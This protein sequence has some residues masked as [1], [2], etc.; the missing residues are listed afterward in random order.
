MWLGTTRP[1][2]M[3][4]RRLDQS[5]NNNG[6][7]MPGFL[8]SGPIEIGQGEKRRCL[9]GVLPKKCKSFSS[10]RCHDVFVAQGRDPD[11]FSCHFVT[12][13]E[14]KL[15]SRDDRAEHGDGHLIPP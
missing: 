3:H 8:R 7:R 12:T 5:G 14:D 11:F 15:H 13:G 6:F 2:E 1:G 4:H 10:R 9:T